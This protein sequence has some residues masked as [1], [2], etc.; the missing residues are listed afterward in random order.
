[1][2]AMPTTVFTTRSDQDFKARLEQLGYS[3]PVSNELCWLH[4]KK[5]VVRD[6]IDEAAR[7][8]EEVRV[9]RGA[10]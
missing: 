9:R 6:L 2:S 1:M 7:F 10:S 5:P 4:D 8:I 3:Y